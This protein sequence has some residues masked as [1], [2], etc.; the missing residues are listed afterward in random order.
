MD[1]P[2][3]NEWMAA[4]GVL[5]APTLHRATRGPPLGAARC[6]FGRRGVFAGLP[7]LLVVGPHGGS[8]RGRPSPGVGR[9]CGLRRVAWGMSTCSLGAGEKGKGARRWSPDVA[10]PLPF[11]PPPSRAG[12]YAAGSIDLLKTPTA[13]AG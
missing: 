7:A 6:S 13:A 4:A 5:H 11:P 12:T 1:T 2:W 10:I 8:G 9:G 3:S